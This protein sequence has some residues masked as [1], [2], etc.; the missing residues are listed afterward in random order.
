[1]TTTGHGQQA[2]CNAFFL[3]RRQ[4]ELRL[5]KRDQFVCVAVYQQQGRRVWRGMQQRRG[6]T[7]GRLLSCIA[8]LRLAAVGIPR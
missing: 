7:V 5:L 1:M 2:G 4:Q 3:E 6:V 8:A